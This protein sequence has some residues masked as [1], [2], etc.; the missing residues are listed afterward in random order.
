[1]L[2]LASVLLLNGCKE[3]DPIDL[4]GASPSITL[5]NTA[6]SGMPGNTVISTVTINAPN[7]LNTLIIY[8]DGSLFETV[9]FNNEKTA[10]FEFTYNIEST[11]VAGT[12]INFSFEAIDSL[13]RKSDQEIFTVT[14]LELSEKEI[15]QVSGE[16]SANTT[17]TSDKIWRLN[18]LVK[19]MDGATL[20]IEPGTLIIGAKDSK[21]TLLINRGGKIIAD[22]TANAPIVF[23]SESEVGNRVPGDWGGIVICGR[24]P[25]N[26]G[27][28][29][30]LEGDYG[31]L[32]GGNVSN[33]NSGVLRYVRIEFAGNA[34]Q[35]NKETNSLTLASVGNATVIEHVQCSYGFDDSFEFFGGTVNAKY[36]VSYRT[37]D[38]DFDMDFGHNGFIQFAIA[39]RDANLGDASYSNGFEIDNDGAGTVSTPYTQ[40]VFSNVSIIGPKYTADNV[41]LP[42]LQNAA[43]FRKN[44][45]PCLYNSFLTGFPTGLFIDD[46]KPGVSQH[47]LNEELQIRNVILAGVE[48]WGNNNW[49][50]SINNSNSPLKQVNANVASG[51]EVNTWYNTST[52]NNQILNTWQDAGI[53]QSLY[54]TL[55]PKVTPNTGSILL[56]AARWDNTPKAGS[57][58]EKVEFAGAIGTVDWTL[59]WCQWDPSVVVYY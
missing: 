10:S 33:D 47:A 37:K 36:L 30:E 50:G 20:N 23:T 56:T 24:A 27:A 48:N 22:G 15:V 38:D 9:T 31:A 45:M 12:V 35:A 51:F 43:Q 44:S 34:I 4:T 28:S 58:F 39:I 21:G 1:M 57:F 11:Q 49:G 6:A 32:Y 26:Q 42:H 19:V 55:N 41:V 2:L 7:G 52:Y 29:V 8:K 13:N 17:W 16:L 25:N 18:G 46:T 5:T 53:D 40:T 54:T 3:D 14:V 59:G